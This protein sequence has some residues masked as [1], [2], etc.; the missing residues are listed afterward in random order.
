MPP[1][2]GAALPPRW[3]ITDICPLP[4]SGS[5]F[6]Q[7]QP[8]DA[9]EVGVANPLSR[10][11]LQLAGLLS[12][13][14]IAVVV[15]Y[16]LHGGSAV[17]NP[18]AEAAQRT[19]AMPGAKL[20]IEVTYSSD[21]S[22]KTVTG[23]GTGVYD[24]RT[25]RSDTQL[26]IAV[27]GGK[28]IWIEALGNQKTIYTR[29][30]TFE[31]LLPPGKVWLGMQPLLGHDPQNEMGG[32]P[33]AQ[34]ML[35][36]LEAAGGGAEA[37][38]HE[39][40]GGH[41]T[42]RYRTTIDPAR[43]AKVFA[44]GGDRTLAREYE[45][46]A[47]QEPEPIQ[48]EVWIDDHGLA[49]LVDVQQKMPFATGKTLNMDTRIE[50]SDFGHKAKI[51][52]PPKRE[53]FDYTPILRAELGLV[54]G[55]GLGLPAPRSA[56]KPLAAS[57]FRKRATA[58][59]ERTYDAA[60]ARLPYEQNLIERIKLM[61]RGRLESGAALPLFRRLAHWLEGPIYKLWRREYVQLQALA[62]PASD[63]AAFRRFQALEAMDTEWALASARGFQIAL[64]K[65]PDSHGQEAAHKKREAAAEKIA[66][67]LGI[68]ACGQKLSA[69]GAEADPA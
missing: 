40:V 48:V 46:I 4:L 22:S 5:R 56:A 30:S 6:T 68:P 53:V 15:N 57:G 25:G 55:H 45:A 8:R 10:R 52:L 59:C 34:G 1:A 28:S 12:L 47:E 42:T 19:A 32:G 33:G 67:E 49:R 29:T 62:P 21:E 20:K 54:D 41:P 24:G 50:Y 58:I 60:R 3:A 16:L 43:E 26:T 23:T 11:L 36:E 39:S 17:V 13:L 65:M 61:D 66:A 51:P 31:G 18:V 69:Q 63:A 37:V 64:T 14:L 9:D 7:G 44:S 27:P 2:R 38:G 35:S